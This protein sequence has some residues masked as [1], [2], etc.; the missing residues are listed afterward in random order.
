MKR[1]AVIFDRDG[2]LNRDTGYPHRPDQIVWTE[3]AAEA[4]RAVN[5]AGLLALVATNQSGVGR[6][7]FT[8][9]AVEALH[10]WMIAELAA[11]GARIDGVVYCPDHPDRATDRRK[12]GPGMI[13]ELIA[14]YDLDPART[15]LI[16][17]KP[18]DLEAAA[19]AGVE[20][21]MFESGS[22][23]VLVRG[24]LGASPQGLP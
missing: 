5:G 18:S 21:L 10:A 9:E 17:D 24:R 20:G 8:A 3:G 16:G 15:L 23:A 2:V 6:G 13:L 7:Y 14:R 4:V 11:K 22:L 1:G 19:A 12:P